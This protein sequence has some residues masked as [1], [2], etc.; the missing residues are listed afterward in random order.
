MIK[1]ASQD[2]REDEVVDAIHRQAVH[3]DTFY[4]PE[5]WAP[6]DAEEAMSKVIKYMKK[7]AEK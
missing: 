4:H 2:A 1:R 3:I 5:V 7:K 6:R